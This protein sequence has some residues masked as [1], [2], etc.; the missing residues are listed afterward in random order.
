MKV[1]IL[2]G[3]S[4]TRLWP[5]SRSTHPKQ[6]LAFGQEHSLLQKT[7]LRFLKELGGENI[8]VVTSKEYFHLVR[9]Q[10]S[11]LDPPLVHQ[12]CL[13]P[14]QKNTAPAVAWALKV[15]EENYH[16]KK[17]EAVLICPSDHWISPEEIFL[18]NVGEAISFAEQGNIVTF[19]IRP[20][21]PETGYGYIR[22]S[23]GGG[24]SPVEA[25]V[26]KPDLQTATQYILGGQH[27][28]NA[29]IFLLTQESFWR[30][31]MEHAPMLGKYADASLQELSEMFTTLPEVS[32]DYAVMEKTKRAVVMPLEVTWSDV[33]SWDSLYDVLDKDEE[34]NVT[35]G[36]VYA[37]D[38]KKSLIIGG[39]RL[40]STI[41]L[42]DTLVIDTEDALFIAKRGESQRVRAL[43]DALKAKG[44]KQV[45]EHTE[46][47][48]PWGSYTVLEEGLRY[49]I[50]RISVTPQA[51]LSLQLHYHRSEHWV[52]VQGT[53]KVLIGEK[54]MLLHENES[55]YVPRSSIHRLE[56]PGKLSLEIIEVQVGEYLSEDDIVRLED[57]YNRV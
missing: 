44:S 14:A 56:N 16:L 11:S 7:V 17:Q 42:E 22:T 20:S 15:L 18:K 21:H 30:E 48:R 32:F 25:F 49:K 57:I 24:I 23:L 33:G 26:E 50:K 1:I 37:L 35:I 28:W 51:R 40:I 54:E 47:H 31:A 13:E 3:G 5:L 45:V 12:I 9:A 38:T 36:N 39:K 19:G 27:L 6:F 2:A 4:G 46:V 10:L 55:V 34:N 29:G 8:L 52:V 41:G 53:A 43:V